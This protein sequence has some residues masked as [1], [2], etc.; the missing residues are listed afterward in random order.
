MAASFAMACFVAWFVSEKLG[1]KAVPAQLL[2]RW[3]RDEELAAADANVSHV[4]G[5]VYLEADFAC[6]A[7]M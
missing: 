4:L 6:D 1:G 3:L 2:T 5:I 7:S